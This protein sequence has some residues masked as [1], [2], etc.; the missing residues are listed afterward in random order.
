LAWAAGL[1]LS[2]L[3]LL[4][5]NFNLL[6]PYEPWTQILLALLLLVISGGFFSGYLGGRQWWRFIPAWIMSALAAMVLLDTVPTMP[7]EVIAALLFIGMSAAFV[8]IYLL[9][10]QEQ[11]WA[12]LPAGFTLVIALLVAAS[13]LTHNITYLGALLFGG[14]GAVFFV[15]YA[16]SAGAQQWWSLIPGSV[17]LIFGLLILTTEQAGPAG[18]MRWWP[19][20]LIIIGL[21]IAWYSDSRPATRATTTTARP[22]RASA[23]GAAD[24]TPSSTAVNTKAPP[25]DR[26]ISQL[27][28]YEQ[29]A[30]GTS[31]DLLPDQD[32]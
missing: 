16:I 13:A 17:L 19:I 21:V 23:H 1:V 18:Y 3:V 24:N 9:Q 7:V 14:M 15:L 26:K 11:W 28:D 6:A 2:G 20:L 8:H 30:P 29:P 5:W 10:R 32:E 4:I 22:Q 27:G 12:L 31:V 25:A